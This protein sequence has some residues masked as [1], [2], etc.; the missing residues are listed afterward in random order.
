MTDSIG[1]GYTLFDPA[2]E[3]GLTATGASLGEL[4]THAAQGVLALLV[5][6]SPIASRDTRAIQVQASNV[7]ALL[8]AWLQELLRWFATD[9][10]V[11]A[12]YHVDEAGRTELHGRLIGETFHPER[13][14]AGTDLKG[15]TPQQC[16][17]T[18]TPD[19]W[20]ARV[21]FDV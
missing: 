6:E 17:V 12:V 11:P 14:M 3:V 8:A 10:F 2:M 13:H 21:V 7:E 20:A 4:F 15:V 16:V 1:N 9:R 19:G 18:E 5:G